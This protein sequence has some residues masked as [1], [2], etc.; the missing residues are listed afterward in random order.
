MNEAVYVVQEEIATPED[1]DL[2]MRLGTN[3]PRGPIE[4]GQAIG[5]DRLARILQRLAAQ[6]GAA[7]GPSR[8]LWVLDAQTADDVPSEEHDSFTGVPL[9]G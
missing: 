8:A 6:D 4:W 5:G 9:G 1:V 7:F 3:Y 2:A